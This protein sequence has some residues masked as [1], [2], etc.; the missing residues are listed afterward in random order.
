MEEALA[1]RDT[2]S[3]PPIVLAALGPAMLQLAAE[4]T[5]GAHTYFVPVE[6]TARAREIL[7]PDPLLAPE[8][9]A[10]LETDPS[11][12]RG[13]AREHASYYLQLPNYVNN[14][15]RLGWD[16]E[17]LA[18]LSDRLIDA[19]V[20]WGDVKAVAGRVRAHRDAGADH[21][22]LQV[23]RSDPGEIPSRDTDLAAALLA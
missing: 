21:V 22:A 11:A 1:S 8:Q 16:E 20:A 10:V 17:D 19:V 7:G 14:L 6:H 4:R 23:V 9:A 5:A 12:A 3:R 2:T 15:R 18:G 13:L